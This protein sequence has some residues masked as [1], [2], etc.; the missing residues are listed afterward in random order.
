MSTQ[1]LKLKGRGW[2][3]CAMMGFHINFNGHDHWPIMPYG[4]IQTD[5]GTPDKCCT[6]HVFYSS[7]S[8]PLI[9]FFFYFLFLKQLKQ[10]KLL[11]IP[12]NTDY[13]R[14]DEPNICLQQPCKTIYIGSLVT[15]FCFCFSRN[16]F[17][18][19]PSQQMAT[20]SNKF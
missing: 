3:C 15:Y 18:A 1:Q 8:P 7:T 19:E 13:S 9:I 6:L 10:L 5:N 11:Q 17:N 16:M 4:Q 2:W 14:T 20:T 12:D